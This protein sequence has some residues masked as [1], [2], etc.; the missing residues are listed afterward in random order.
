MNALLIIGIETSGKT[1]SCAVSDGER[2]VA[3]SGFVTALTHSQ[4]ILPLAQ[5]V[6]ADAGLDIGAADCFAVSK[7]PGSYTGLRIGIAAV[8]GLCFPDGTSCVGIST[9]EALAF[10]VAAAQGTAIFAMMKARP[11]ISYCG[12]YAPDGNKLM[13]LVPDAVMADEAVK[14]LAARF[15]DILAVGDG[16][17]LLAGC[18]GVRLAP[19]WANAPRASALCGCALA[20]RDEWVDAQQLA[21]AY[22]QETKAEKDMRHR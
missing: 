12:V 18:A 5:R 22:L 15:S 10:P 3:E 9:L 4:V 17:S 14:T 16:A 11:G 8:K 13:C 2:I 6:V 1:A 19:E 7:G 20:R 21:A